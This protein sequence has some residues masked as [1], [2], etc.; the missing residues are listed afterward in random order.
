[1]SRFN[2]IDE[3]WIPVRFPDGTRDELGIRDTLLRSEGDR[4]HRR[5][6]AAGGSGSAPFSARGPV[7]RLGRTDRHRSG[8]GAVQGRVCRAKKSRPTWKS[9]GIGSGC[10][11]RSIRLG[12]FQHLNRRHGEPGRRLPLSTMLTMPRFSS[13]MSMFEASRHDSGAA[14]MCRW[15][16][17][18]QTFSVSAV[19]RANYRTR[20]SSFRNGGDVH[21]PG[22]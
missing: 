20:D 2:L 5:P 14:A 10:L 4:G 15:L 22:E 3:K 11:M 17:A 6:V 8:Q 18:T 12:K 21:S 7:P 13:I 1:M 19:A 9:G 16:L